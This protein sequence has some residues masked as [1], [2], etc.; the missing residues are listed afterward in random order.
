[1][2]WSSLSGRDADSAPR[3]RPD[4]PSPSEVYHTAKPPSPLAAS[5]PEAWYKS[6]VSERKY[7][8]RGYMDDGGTEEPRRRRKSGPRTRP[9]GPRG[10]GLGAPTAEAFRCAVCGKRAT[11]PGAEETAVVCASCAADLHTCTNCRHFDSSAPLECRQ[12]L[13]QRVAAKAKRNDCELFDA[14]VTKEIASDS[15]RPADAKA[16]FDALFDL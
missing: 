3:R 13:S 2:D 6:P 8:Q 7:R 10:R 14:K 15:D 4:G 9:E 16:A 11:P 1:M 5:P 12:P